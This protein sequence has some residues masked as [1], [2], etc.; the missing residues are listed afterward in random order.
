MDCTMFVLQAQA[1]H[2][3]YRIISIDARGHGRTS[4]EG[5]PFTYWDL[6]EDTLAIMDA[7]GVQ[8]QS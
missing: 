1:L 5:R 3:Q 7:A 2:Y 8:P 4:D 6:A